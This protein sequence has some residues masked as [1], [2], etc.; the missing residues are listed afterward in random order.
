MDRA[1]KIVMDTSLDSLTTG[2]LFNIKNNFVLKDLT[3]VNRIF[4]LTKTF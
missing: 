2:I 4:K 1:E 3:K